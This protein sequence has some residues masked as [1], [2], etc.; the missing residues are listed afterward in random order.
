MSAAADNNN[1]CIVAA[2]KLEELYLDD[3]I[4]YNIACLGFDDIYLYDN[5]VDPSLLPAHLQ[6]CPVV[7]RVLDSRMLAVLERSGSRFVPV[8]SPSWLLAQY[9]PVHFKEHSPG[10]VKAVLDSADVSGILPPPGAFNGKCALEFKNSR[11]CKAYHPQYIQL[12]RV[13]LEA[14]PTH[15]DRV[16]GLLTRFVRRRIMVAD[17]DDDDDLIDASLP[18]VLLKDVSGQEATS[19]QQTL[20]APERTLLTL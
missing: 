4:T 1:I 14:L 6:G 10:K 19:C 15:N 11:A 7:C 9:D 16:K 2:V 12:M 17:D 13:L 20:Q 5:N 18:C 8:L 3:W